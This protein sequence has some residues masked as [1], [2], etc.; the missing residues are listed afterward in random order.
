VPVVGLALCGFPVEARH[1]SVMT[2]DQLLADALQAKEFIALRST[3]ARLVKIM[4]SAFRVS[5]PELRSLPRLPSGRHGTAWPPSA[6]LLSST[7]ACR[8]I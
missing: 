6:R 5:R 2:T 4:Q 8:A 7:P 3:A 1:G